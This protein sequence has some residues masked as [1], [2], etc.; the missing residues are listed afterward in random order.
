MHDMDPH[1][2]RDKVRQLADDLTW[3]EDHCR[4]QADLSVHAAHLRLAAALT[5]NVI[6]PAAEGQAPR[7][8]F[9][10]VVGGAGAGKSTVVNFLCGAVVAEA[11]PQA[12][13][14][15]HPTAFLP[16][17]L[18]VAWPTY[19]GFLG[20]LTRLS[21]SKP[22]NLDEDVY[23]AKRIPPPTNGTPDPLSDFVVWD[24][25]DMTTWASTGYVSRLME[26]VALADVVVYVASDERYN[27]EVPT[28][29]LNLLI[30][31]GKAV[32]VCLTKMRESD[33]APLIEHFRKEVLG[34][35]PKSGGDVPPIPCVAFP[36]MPAD[37]RSDPAGKGAKHRVALLNQ[38]L[39]LCPSPESA[40][41]RTVA[42]AIRYLET[43][44]EGLLDVA[45]KDL[46]E[47]EN[48]RSIVEAGKTQ[49][50]DRYRREFLAGEQ[51]RRFD[52]TREQVMEMLELP[53]AGK[54]VSGTLA[55]LRS[56]YRMAREFVAKTLVRPQMPN[57]S[58]H[59]ICSAALAA[60]LDGLQAETLRRAGT[61][62]IWKQLSHGFDAGLKMQAQDRFG[63]EFRSFELKE[64][65]EL[66]RAAR[67]VPEY[68]SQH[69]ALLNTLRLGTVALDL[70]AGGLVLWL[71]WVP[72]WYHLLLIPVAVSGTRQGVEITVTQVVDSGRNRVRHQR[73]TL[74]E[75][76]LTGPLAKWLSEWPT[77]TG[78]T[79]E[80]LQQV[81]GRVPQ[82]IRE[83][84]SFVKPATPP[85]PRPV[86]TP[87]VE[88]P[89]SA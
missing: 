39:A 8:L 1:D 18:G 65:D 36:Q 60:W 6:G 58:E 52:R 84:S 82:T 78:S 81:L 30:K 77:S 49:F 28:Q 83:L 24:C 47:L 66:D 71:T 50:E 69:H 26:V 85:D 63:Q 20:P 3:L 31:A 33:A 57:L 89:V 9:V 51:F 7:P 67:V 76:H 64:T 72:A 68:L 80:K 27:D 4:R 61:H 45:R 11:N 21:E 46:T 19:L 56:P 48:W 70:T 38:L 74:L 59:T 43:A 87:R 75:E 54:A 42:N 79:L 13:Y 10:A 55:L 25:P 17:A 5:R 86:E 40:R 41:S 29:F 12:G 32:V 23:Q 53:G 37:V 14:T 35:V 34:R 44:G 88:T 73:E 16:P 15:R 62:P 2:H 22:G